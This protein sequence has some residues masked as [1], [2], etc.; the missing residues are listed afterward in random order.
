MHLDDVRIIPGATAGCVVEGRFGLD[1]PHYAGGEALASARER[2][3]LF[4]GGP[5]GAWINLSELFE[6]PPGFFS[7]ASASDRLSLR[8]PG[9]V[10]FEGLL[11]SM[12]SWPGDREPRYLEWAALS[13]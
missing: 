2:I 7:R 6:D 10:D 1:T 13:M 4:M 3:S 8:L 9:L 12:S 11:Y 5:Y